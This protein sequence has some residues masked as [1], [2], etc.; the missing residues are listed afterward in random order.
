MKNVHITLL[1][2]RFKWSF[3]DRWNIYKLGSKW[4]SCDSTREIKQRDVCR[5]SGSVIGPWSVKCLRVY[6][7]LLNYLYCVFV[8]LEGFGCGGRV[9]AAYKWP[10]Q[11][12]NPGLTCLF[13]F[14]NNKIK[15]TY[16]LSQLLWGR[17]DVSLDFFIF[18]F[19][20]SY[21]WFFR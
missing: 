3:F 4:L 18:L 7:A 15:I 11:E 19:S 5:L 20:K 12:T 13:H 10:R 9:D 6:Y 16:D 14:R 2:G 1:A 8:T 21:F 17:W